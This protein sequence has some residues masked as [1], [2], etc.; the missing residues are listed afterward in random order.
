MNINRVNLSNEVKNIYQ[1]A[2]QLT[3]IQKLVCLVAFTVLPYCVY[4]CYKKMK[5]VCYN[6]RR[7]KNEKTPKELVPTSKDPINIKE[8]ID[9]SKERAIVSETHNTLSDPIRQ[10]KAPDP[11]IDSIISFLQPHDVACLKGVNHQ[12]NKRS[13]QTT[14]LTQI[15]V[16]T[17]K[18]NFV[19]NQLIERLRSL[20][21]NKFDDLIKSFEEIKDEKNPILLSN[22]LADV[23]THLTNIENMIVKKLQGLTL[24]ELDHFAEIKKLLPYVAVAHASIEIDLFTE[25]SMKLIKQE[26]L[27][28]SIEIAARAE[29]ISPF[30]ERLVHEVL[31][32]ITD[33]YKLAQLSSSYTTLIKIPEVAELIDDIILSRIKKLSTEEKEKLSK[34]NLPYATALYSYP[35]QSPLF[36][37]VNTVELLEVELAALD[38]KSKEFEL[39]KS[40]LLA[41]DI[42]ADC[43][44][45]QRTSLIIKKIKLITNSQQLIRVSDFFNIVGA[46]K[47]VLARFAANLI[48]DQVL[49]KQQLAKIV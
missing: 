32:P 1:Q 5:E 49:K 14:L 45:P 23:K 12:F 17:K 16:N 8:N 30:I 18:I 46:K 42:V 44:T 33:L 39:Q 2:Q 43:I 15:N 28:R 4:H 21:A 6:F 3:G 25:P 37:Y 48:R 7:I 31:G 34:I 11:L 36:H 26:V 35:W 22:N 47:P 10:S 13:V 27:E 24:D 40:K 20:D 41:D 29:G 9:G 38:P 19:L